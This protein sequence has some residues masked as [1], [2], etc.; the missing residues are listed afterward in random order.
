MTQEY[1]ITTNGLVFRIE[2]LRPARFWTKA[3]WVPLYREDSSELYGSAPAEFDTEPQAQKA[4]QKIKAEIEAQE[5]GFQPIIG[6]VR[7]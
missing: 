7:S 5:R 1:R 3:A 2:Y 6:E 4:L